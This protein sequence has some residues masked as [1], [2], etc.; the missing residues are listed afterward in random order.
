M[1]RAIVPALHLISEVVSVSMAVP[2]ITITAAME[3]EGP[4]AKL[5]AGQWP[6]WDFIKNPTNAIKSHPWYKFSRV[7]PPV[8]EGLC[9]NIPTFVTV[10]QEEL[11]EDFARDLAMQLGID[12]D[13]EWREDDS[14]V[15]SV[16]GKQTSLDNYYG[17]KKEWVES[18]AWLTP[19]ATLI[20]AAIDTTESPLVA[21][22][23]QS[24]MPPSKPC[25]PPTAPDANT[26]NSCYDNCVRCNLECTPFMKAGPAT[27][28]PRREDPL[29]LGLELSLILPPRLYPCPARH[30][31]PSHSKPTT[32]EKRRCSPMPITSSS[33]AGP[34]A[35]LQARPRKRPSP[36]I[37]VQVPAWQS[38]PFVVPPSATV[39][40]PGEHDLQL[41]VMQL[42]GLI[43]DLL[44]EIADLRGTVDSQGQSME[45]LY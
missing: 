40:R 5:T 21:N 41:K 11:N 33:K 6:A 27:H 16:K 12:E 34:A 42:S 26:D 15:D 3:F 4:K 10:T 20:P 22:P 19:N 37:Y 28:S 14:R 7:P 30:C 36:N 45:A 1:C 29:E 18:N 35:G 25:M 17:I 8:P 9:L 23:P 24:R 31:S 13:V 39:V 32:A 38:A 43:C 2:P 44:Q